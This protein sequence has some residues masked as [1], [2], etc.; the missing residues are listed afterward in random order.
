MVANSLPFWLQH[1]GQPMWR[2]ANP[3]LD[4]APERRCPAAVERALGDRWMG[5][6]TGLVVEVCDVEAVARHVDAWSDL[7]AR[8]FEPNVFNEPAF[9]LSAARHFAPAHQPSFVLIWDPSV[10]RR[11]LGLCAVRRLKL[12]F[13]LDAWTAWSHQQATVAAPLLDRN[14]AGEALDALL[15]W[16][17]GPPRAASGLVLRGVDA[18]GP[19]GRLLQT[20]GPARLAVLDRRSRAVLRRSS[21]E[22]PLVA[23]SSKRAKEMRRQQRRLADTGLVD[24]EVASGGTAVREA[25]ERFLELEARGWKGARD[26][27]LL[28]DPGLAAFTRSMTRLLAREDKCH[29]HSLNVDGVPVAMGIVLSSGDRSFFWKTAYDETQAQWSPGK[30]LALALTTSQSGRATIALT[31]SCAVPDHPMIDRLWS[32]R[33]TVTDVFVAAPG[34]F[35]RFARDAKLILLR[36]QARAAAKRFVLAVRRLVGR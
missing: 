27:A 26:T 31:D 10:S 6:P 21:T 2:S 30:Q 7:V 33:M 18:N 22:P 16:C 24:V 20:R 13:G 11:L 12:G 29:I 32:D 36:A 35:R 17:G 5:A 28:R 23:Q 9:A 8:C 14:R 25:T 1:T 3:D 15:G 19:L 34:G 4:A